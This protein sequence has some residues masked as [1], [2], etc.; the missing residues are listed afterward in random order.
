MNIEMNVSKIKL[1][2]RQICVEMAKVL[3][4]SSLIHQPGGSKRAF[5]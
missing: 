5:P 2:I 1:I 3:R 4:V